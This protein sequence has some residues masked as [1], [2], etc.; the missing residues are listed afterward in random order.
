[1]LYR[2]LFSLNFN[3]IHISLRR[4]SNFSCTMNKPVS[5]PVS[6]ALVQLT[7][8]DRVIICF[9]FQGRTKSR[10]FTFNRDVDETL[11]EVLLR[12]QTNTTKFVFKPKKIKNKDES[13]SEPAQN[14]VCNVQLLRLPEPFDKIM[15]NDRISSTE[16]PLPEVD[17]T[18]TCEEAFV[19]EAENHILRVEDQWYIIIA[20]P[21]TILNVNLPNSI[22]VGHYL[23]PN[24]LELENAYIRNCHMDWF[25]SNQSFEDYKEAKTNLQSV[26]WTHIFSRSYFK[27]DKA[28]VNKL[29][30]V[31]SILNQ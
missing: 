19:D 20:N 18:V 16:F 3:Y 12:I 21:P 23:Y 2:K 10:Q 9:N 28:F 7:E 24:N 8:E 17:P 6:K 26:E 31:C 29:L 1:M 22:I 30:K 14:Q 13:S 5:I 15:E 11:G 4:L 25:L 27:V